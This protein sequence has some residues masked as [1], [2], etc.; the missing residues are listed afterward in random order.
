MLGPVVPPQ[1]VHNRL[2]EADGCLALLLTTTSRGPSHVFHKRLAP[3]PSASAELPKAHDGERE[4]DALASRHPSLQLLP[5]TLSTAQ[6]RSTIDPSK[7]GRDAEDMGIDDDAGVLLAVGHA[8]HQMGN[9]GP[10]SCHAEQPVVGRR[11]TATVSDGVRCG[12]T[13]VLGL[14]DTEVAPPH[15]ALELVVGQSG[16][17][18]RA[19]ASASAQKVA[20]RQE[21][22][23]VAA[24]H[25]EKA[26]NER[27]EAAVPRRTHVR[28]GARPETNEE[29]VEVIN[30]SLA[31]ISVRGDEPVLG[32]L[33]RN[34]RLGNRRFQLNSQ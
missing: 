3:L 20:R 34:R 10:D 18:L 30:A 31:R 32:E 15:Q 11:H 4:G 8:A 29:R 26:S 33:R 7:L 22:H 27:P 9:L 14:C 13:H 12:G 17:T 19:L 28:F 6:R 16:D 1:P 24:L 5:H 25:R 21:G 2:C 23:I